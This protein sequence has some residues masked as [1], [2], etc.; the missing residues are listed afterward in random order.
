MP[1]MNFATARSLMVEQ[2]I[3]TWDVLDERV[4]ELVARMPREDFVPEAYRKLAYVDMS[5]PLG[6]GEVMMAPKLEAR[7]LQELDIGPKDKIL[8]IGTGSGFMTALLASLGAHVYSVEILPDFKM[9]TARKLAAHNVRNVTLDVGDGA[10][11][12]DRHGPY[13]VILLTG[14]VPVLPASFAQSLSVDGRMIAIVGESPA[15]EVKRITR[16]T[17]ESV[18]EVSLFETDLPP[19]QNAQQPE[20]FIF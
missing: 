17:P 7:L 2:Q 11:G 10:R 4:L 19:L 12:W 6:R 20:R 15:M 18:R 14:S 9:Q 8:E 5:I 16:L 3:R 1:E 13:D